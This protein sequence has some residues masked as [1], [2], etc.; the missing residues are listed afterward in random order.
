[1]KVS[2]VEEFKDREKKDYRWWIKVFE[3]VKLE[4][5]ERIILGLKN[6][7]YFLLEEMVVWMSGRNY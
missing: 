5:I 1:M 6:G 3:E 4:I 2:R 7:C